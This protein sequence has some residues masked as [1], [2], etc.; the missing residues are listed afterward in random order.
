MPLCKRPHIVAKSKPVAHHAAMT[1]T[2]LV[3][4]LVI[5][6]GD[7]PSAGL[8]HELAATAGLIVAADGGADRALAL[9]LT[10]GAVV[11]DLDSVSPAA[12]AALGEG[13]F[14]RVADPSRTDL[15]K[16]I[17]FAI[18]AGAKEI[19]VIGAGGGRADHALANL[20]V[21]LVY[22]G[23]ARVTLHDDLF[24]IS[25]VEGAAEID[26]PP[27]TVVSLVALIDCAGVT[28]EG[29]RWNLNN[30]ALAFSPMGVHNEV[31][32]SPARVTVRSGNLLLFTGRW[33]ERH[34]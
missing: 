20:S 22:R 33:I 10:P 8:A 12:A 5:A 34:T 17:E 32:V 11:G 15:Q 13:R 19:D 6:N 4:A 2:R 27:G 28:T 30:A 3:R 23:R 21:L 18:G 7:P 14:H 9:G 25:L 1:F 29:L 24:R 26:A 31:A 16:A